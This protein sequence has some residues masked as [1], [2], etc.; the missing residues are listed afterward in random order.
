MFPMNDLGLKLYLLF[1][2]SWFLHLSARLP[3]LGDVRVDF[4]LILSMLATIVIGKKSDIQQNTS[5]DISRALTILFVYVVVTLPFVQ[6]P[7]SV[8]NA[9]I[10]NFIKV[11]IFYYFTVSFCN[12]STKAEIISFYFSLLPMLSRFRAR[13]SSLDTRLLGIFRCNV[14]V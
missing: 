1:T 9:G 12:I 5:N 6:W 7:G 11:I 4:L 3:F 8:L 14:R 10:P 2:V 13:L